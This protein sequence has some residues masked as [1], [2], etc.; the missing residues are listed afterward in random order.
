MDLW[1]ALQITDASM[2]ACT[3]A[4]GKTSLLTTLA[5]C[6]RRR[7]LPVF[8]TA[9]TK[10]Y[11]W[12]IQ[13]WDPII[14]TDFQH[15]RDLVLRAM[16][17]KGSTAWFSSC[18]K[19]KVI[20]LPVEYISRLA[21]SLRP[22]YCLL[23][24]ADGAKEKLLKTPAVHEPIV[25]EE[26]THTVGVLNAQAL[27]RPLEAAIVHRLDRTCELLSKQP[28]ETITV[29]DF[30]ILASHQQ[31]IFQYHRGQCGLVVTGVETVTVSWS[32]QL[33]GLLQDYGCPA[34][35]C[36]LAR[37]FGSTMEP[38]GVYVL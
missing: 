21:A 27:G 31:G 4:G 25:P 13:Q 14:A 35:R 5:A 17:D 6:G 15:G 19:D 8:I 33:L 34:E 11:T 37:G 10:M 9:T 23:V 29:Q 18:D 24:E 26:T 12:Q 36:I 3:G 7:K 16:S 32:G 30:A 2:V 28:G 1:E 20:G 38:V 22:P